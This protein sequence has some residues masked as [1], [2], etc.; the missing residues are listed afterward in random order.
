MTSIVIPL[1][2]H[3]HGSRWGDKELRYALRSVEKHLSGYGEVFIIGYCPPWLQ[4]VVHIPATDGDK[5]YEHERNIFNKIM[6]A[7]KDERVSDTFLF[8]NDDHFLLQDF[9][10]NGITPFPFYYEGCLKDYLSRTDPYKQTIQNTIDWLG[11]YNLYFDV[12]CPMTI[13]TRWFPQA[14]AMLDWLK[15]WGYCIKT[16][17]AK[18]VAETATFPPNPREIADLKIRDVLPSSKIRELIAGRPWFSMSDRAREGGMEVVLQ[19]LYPT[20]SKY[21]K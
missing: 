11:P 13:N 18:Y 17:Y 15:K 6:L 4:N 5:T 19:E 16:V 21:E 12:H 14:T 2:G 7:C 3:G 20:K 10:F 9:S 8:M 1:A